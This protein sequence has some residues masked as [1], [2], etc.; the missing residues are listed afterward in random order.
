MTEAQSCHV[1]DD[2]H[3]TS[4]VVRRFLA[5]GSGLPHNTRGHQC[6]QL[7]VYG[8]PCAARLGHVPEPAPCCSFACL[9]PPGMF[10]D[11]S[12]RCCSAVNGHAEIC[13][14]S[15]CSSVCLITRHLFLT[16]SVETRDWWRKLKL[17]LQIERGLLKLLST[18]LK[19]P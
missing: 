11:S 6:R 5:E 14:G 17:V 13:G 12:S 10:R 16:L 8:S 19:C 15:P 2:R 1:Q 7:R 18:H 4:Q 9:C 3:S